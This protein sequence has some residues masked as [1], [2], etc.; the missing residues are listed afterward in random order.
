MSRL[1]ELRSQSHELKVKM[2]EISRIISK[3]KEDLN[4]SMN[5]FKGWEL[6]VEELEVEIRILNKQYQDFAKGRREATFKNI[7]KDVL[8]PDQFELLMQ[9]YVR[10]TSLRQ[11]ETD[12]WIV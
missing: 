11:G 6:E 7:A 1:E 5:Q 4:A 10:I 12:V 9:E 3:Q 8:A 2:Y